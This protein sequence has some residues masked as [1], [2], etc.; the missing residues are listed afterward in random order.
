MTMKNFQVR[1]A[2]EVHETVKAIA[3]ERSIS[4]ADIIREALEI[5]TVGVAYAE[6]GKRLVWE[7][8]KTGEKLQILIPGFISAARKAAARRVTFDAPVA[9]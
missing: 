2:D 1:L 3:E 8:P 6:E 5:Y 4:I 9:Q 7:D